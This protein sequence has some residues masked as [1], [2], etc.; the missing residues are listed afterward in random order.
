MYSPNERNIKGAY[1]ILN[2][3]NINTE[4]N[5][6]LGSVFGWRFPSEIEPN[7]I[8]ERMTENFTSTN[9]SF[10]FLIFKLKKIKGKNLM[11]LCGNFSNTP[12]LLEYYA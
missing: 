12:N 9:Y 8:L 4:F 10:I 11:C 3:Y 6:E 1:T 2:P 5:V 7:L